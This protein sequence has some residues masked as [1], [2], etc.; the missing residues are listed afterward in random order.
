MCTCPTDP[1]VGE[2]TQVEK[3][4]WTKKGEKKRKK[5]PI[6]SREKPN[7]ICVKSLVPV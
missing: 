3:K 5:I 1:V 7:V 2:K 4:T 6:S